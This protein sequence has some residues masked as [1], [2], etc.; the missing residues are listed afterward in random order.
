VLHKL[1]F[2]ILVLGNVHVLHYMV[3][4]SAGG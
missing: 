1:L 4:T 2:L 3:V